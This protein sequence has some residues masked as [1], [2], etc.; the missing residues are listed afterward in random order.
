MDNRNSD[1]ADGA[2]GTAEAVAA[3]GAAAPPLLFAPLRVLIGHRSDHHRSI[4]GWRRVPFIWFG[5]LLQFGG[6]AVLPFAMLVMSGGGVGPAWLGQAGAA[7]GFL[8]VGAGMHMTQT[9]GLAL[10]T[11]LAPAEARPRRGP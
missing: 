10:A 4:L 9:V 1:P 8:L 6:L 3:S 2:G 7:L 11:D 5:T